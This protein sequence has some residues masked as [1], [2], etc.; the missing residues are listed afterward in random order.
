MRRRGLLAAA[1]CIAFI[2][3]TVGLW[4]TSFPQRWFTPKR[5]ADPNAD[6]IGSSW[7]SKGENA[8]DK[9]VV[10]AK[11]TNENVDWVTNDLE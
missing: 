7:I 4:Q 6:V 3:F 1:A 8:G 11:M 2:I 5:T 9:V 10:I